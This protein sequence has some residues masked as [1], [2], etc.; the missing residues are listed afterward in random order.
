MRS[1]LAEIGLET[2]ADLRTLGAVEAYL[3]LRFAFS[4]VSLN[5]LW[6]LAAGL[7]GRDWRSLTA[8]EKAA[9]KAQLPPAAASHK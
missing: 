5:A 4:R 6:A 2:V 8:Q 7:Q 1:M 9:L 3:R